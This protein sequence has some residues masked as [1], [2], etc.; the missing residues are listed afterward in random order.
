[1]EDYFGGSI[2]EKVVNIV[3]SYID[4]VNRT[5]WRKWRINHA[6]IPQLEGYVPTSIQPDSGEFRRNRLAI[7]R[8]RKRGGRVSSA[9]FPDSGALQAASEQ[10]AE[11]TLDGAF[12]AMAAEDAHLAAT[13]FDEAIGP[14]L[15]AATA[16]ALIN[17]EWR[18]PGSDASTMLNRPSD[19][20]SR[21]SQRIDCLSV[22][23]RP[24]RT[25]KILG[26][27]RGFRLHR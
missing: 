2:S 6:S 10:P 20:P 4:Y 11:T 26:S 3:L 14:D 19:S 12:K 8:C 21:R 7:E 5:V 27:E 18:W 16:N 13:L 9:D 17:T 24:R 25:A 22:R 1:M 23:K 15:D